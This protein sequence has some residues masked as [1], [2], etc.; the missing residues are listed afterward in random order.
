MVLS[1]HD[2]CATVLH[3]PLCVLS[4]RLR[5][6]RR[7]VALSRQG[8]QLPGLDMQLS[9]DILAILQDRHRYGN[10]SARGSGPPQAFN[11]QY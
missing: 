3:L 7:L 5:M 2:R 10:L 8:I 11:V 1:A 4:E 6:F 9:D